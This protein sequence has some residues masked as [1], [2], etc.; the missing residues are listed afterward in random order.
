MFKKFAVVIFSLS[1]LLSGTS[2]AFGQGLLPTPSG[3]QD[4]Q[5][6]DG[7][8]GNCGNY[9]VIDFISLAI[10]ASQWILGMVGV[11]SLV[12]F[13]YGGF[14]FLVS[15]GSSESIKKAKNILV[16]SV[17]GLIIVFSSWLIIKFVIGT[18]GLNWE[19]TTNEMQPVTTTTIE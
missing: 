11:L 3:S 8:E 1:L 17:I 5:C 13:I 2:F 18:M 15:A 16:A 14:T 6:P 7:Y 12:M 9:E 19:G 4:G 10:N